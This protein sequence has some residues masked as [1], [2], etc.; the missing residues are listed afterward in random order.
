[1]PEIRI[2]VFFIEDAVLV[3]MRH[4]TSMGGRLEH[5]YPFVY[6]SAYRSKK[7]VFSLL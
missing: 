6:F 3:R 7:S 2:V 1:M 4:S 5:R